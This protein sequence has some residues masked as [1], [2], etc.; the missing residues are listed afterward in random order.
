MDVTRKQL[1]NLDPKV[2]QIGGPANIFAHVR[3]FPTA[4]MRTVARPNF[5]TLYSSAWIDLTEGP[6]VVSTADTHDRYFLLPMLDMWTDVFAVLGKR[7]SGTSAANFAL[8][9]P[10]WNGYLPPDVE[11]INAPT[12]LVWIIGR[13]QTN[14]VKDY[15][16]V[17]KIQDDYRITLL[18]DWGKTPRMIQQ[19]IDPSVDTRTP[20]RC[21]WSTE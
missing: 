14:G 10:G 15:D 4:A 17:H 7:T 1:T 3:A 19:K 13:T 5:D 18:Q 20:N 9:P 2:S 8:A 12:S 16:A 11:R 6:V 21:D